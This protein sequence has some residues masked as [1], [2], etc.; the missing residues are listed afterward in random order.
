MK[1]RTLKEICDYWE[2]EARRSEVA[3]ALWE[4]RCREAERSL[5]AL[6]ADPLEAFRAGFQAEAIRQIDAWPSGPDTQE[7]TK[8]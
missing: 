2:A 7:P 6:R 8:E 4:R 5:A 1:K 3:A